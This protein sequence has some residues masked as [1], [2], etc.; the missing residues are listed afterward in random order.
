MKLD[1]LLTGVIDGS[2]IEVSGK[3]DVDQSNGT[4]NLELAVAD[5]PVGWDPAIIIMICCDNLRLFSA[6]QAGVSVIAAA[7]TGLRSLQFG[8]H[9][10]TVREGTIV[11]SFGEAVV[12]MKAKGFLFIE[13][14]VVKSRT[15]IL[16]GF[17]NLNKYG[18]I[19]KIVTPYYEKITP[20]GPKTATGLSTYE[21]VC[22][23]GTRMTGHT[24]YPYVFNDGPGLSSETRL[25]V[26]IAETNSLAFLNRTDVPKIK[27]SIKEV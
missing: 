24:N 20:T 11:N 22:A 6:E 27:V 10:N 1:Y 23:D 16:Q 13:D 18:G 12:H 17:S 26:H 3:G 8:S 7:R 15:V 21:L 4:F 14:G 25:Q 9:V 19:E 2:Y 5:A